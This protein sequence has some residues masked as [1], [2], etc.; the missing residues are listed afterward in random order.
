MFAYCHSS[1]DILYLH[2]K[3]FVIAHSYCVSVGMLA[4]SRNMALAEEEIVSA[5]KRLS[6]F[7]QGEDMSSG[8]DKQEVA[9][10]SVQYAF[11]LIKFGRHPCVDCSGWGIYCLRSSLFIFARDA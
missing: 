5:V 7:P 3:Y 10:V 8:T 4:K 2:Q 1:P 9:M 11:V 6:L